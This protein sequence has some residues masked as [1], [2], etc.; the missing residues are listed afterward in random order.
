MRCIP[1]S[2][3]SYKMADNSSISGNNDK[4]LNEKLKNN[5]KKMIRSFDSYIVEAKEYD[6][7][8]ENLKHMSEVDENFHKYELVEYLTDRVD[9][10]LGGLIDKHVNET[11]SGAKLDGDIDQ[12]NSIAQ[13]ISE[14]IMAANE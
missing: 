14:K 10:L 11:F 8:E 13:R 5:L 3:Y 2:K 12:Q 6:Q 9:T 1:E 4:I 7:L